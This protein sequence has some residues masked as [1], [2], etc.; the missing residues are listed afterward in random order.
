MDFFHIFSEFFGAHLLH[1]YCPVWNVRQHDGKL[2]QTG[3][4]S[5]SYLVDFQKIGHSKSKSKKYSFFKSY[6]FMA[7]TQKKPKVTFWC[8]LP[9][10]Q[11]AFKTV[12]SKNGPLLTVV[13]KSGKFTASWPFPA[14][15]PFQCRVHRK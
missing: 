15:R 3:R 4:G 5:K 12:N 2:L 14:S 8:P 9:S 11:E 1:G 7:Y 10:S 6:L 13:W